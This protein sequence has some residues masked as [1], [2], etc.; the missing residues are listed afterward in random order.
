M[1]M[2]PSAPID[3]GLAAGPHTSSVDSAP[4]PISTDAAGDWLDHD[5][6]DLPAL[7][8]RDA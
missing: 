2:T 3:F 4:V 7:V 6:D 1:I 8:G 5:L